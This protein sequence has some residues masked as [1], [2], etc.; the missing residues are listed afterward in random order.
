MAAVTH[1]DTVVH[2]NAELSVTAAMLVR[3]AAARVRQCGGWVMGS[4]PHCILPS[5][6]GRQMSGTAEC[7]HGQLRSKLVIAVSR[8]DTL[9]AQGPPAAF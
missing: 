1:L 3:L 7:T 9:D 2:Y 4:M 6:A 5:A 8:Y